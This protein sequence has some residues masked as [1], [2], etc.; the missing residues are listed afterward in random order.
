[1]FLPIITALERAIGYIFNNKSLAAEALTHSSYAN[2]RAARGEPSAPCNERLEFVGDSV[3]SLVAVEYIYRR[4]PDFTEAGMSRVRRSAV[5][6]SAFGGYA[7][8]IGLGNF[9]LLGKGEEKIGGRENISN[10]E[11]AFE[12]LAGAIYLDGGIRDRKSTR[13]NSSH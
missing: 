11:N 5:S 3:L 10:L 7:A 1:M 8:S 12:A 6:K 13:L 4:Y 2:E 9:L